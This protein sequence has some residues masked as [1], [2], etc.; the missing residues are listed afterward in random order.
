M[1]LTASPVTPAESTVKSCA[2]SPVA[3]AV[4]A[5]RPHRIINSIMRQ[6]R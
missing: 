5:I 6:P 4:P 1:P 3:S 2:F